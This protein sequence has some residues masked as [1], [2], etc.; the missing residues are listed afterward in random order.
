MLLGVGIERLDYTKGIPERLPAVDRLLE[1]TPGATASSSSS[2]RSPCPAGR[3]SRPYQQLDDEVDT[4]VEEI[5]WKWGDRRL[6]AR[7]S[8]SRS[9]T[10]RST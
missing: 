8:T 1:R 7:S 10:A 5:N 9:T 6:A 2:C 4:L 3:T